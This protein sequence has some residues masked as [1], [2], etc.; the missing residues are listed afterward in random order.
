MPAF[1]VLRRCPKNATN[2]HICARNSRFAPPQD[3]PWPAMA[4][5]CVLLRRAVP[6]AGFA[7]NLVGVQPRHCFP[8]NLKISNPFSELTVVGTG[9]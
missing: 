1:G 4:P 2:F 7:K 8:K 3:T 6:H 5:P 9:L